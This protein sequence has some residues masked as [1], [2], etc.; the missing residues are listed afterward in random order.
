MDGDNEVMVGFR[1]ELSIS[2]A[3]AAV[4]LNCSPALVAL[5]EFGKR[6]IGEARRKR[7]EDARTAFAS[8]GM[9]AVDALPEF[10]KPPRSRKTAEG[11]PPGDADEMRGW[12]IAMNLTQESAGPR[13]GLGVHSI[14]AIEG[15]RMRITDRVRKYME[16]EE[17]GRT[18]R[19]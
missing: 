16:S 9:A 18:P 8:G 13:I 14:R 7:L 11:V 15:G 4:V 19:R 10:E 6:R 17:A 12:R 1:R 5:V 3:K 2:Q